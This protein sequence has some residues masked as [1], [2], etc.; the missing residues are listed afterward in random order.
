MYD[1]PNK[2][3]KLKSYGLISMLTSSQS[4]ITLVSSHKDK[5]SLTSRILHRSVSQLL[6]SQGWNMP[7]VTQFRR[8]TSMDARS[9]HVDIS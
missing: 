9:N 4:L 5:G 3:K 7:S 8:I 1:T 6:S 2:E